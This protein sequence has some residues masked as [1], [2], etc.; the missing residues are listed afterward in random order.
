MLTESD[1]WLLPPIMPSSEKVADHYAELIEGLNLGAGIEQY[2][3]VH[4]KDPHLFDPLLKMRQSIIAEGFD[5]NEIASEIKGLSPYFLV[6]L[7]TGDG[8]VMKS[9]IDQFK[10][11]HLVIALSDWQDLATS[12]WTV[13]WQKLVDEQQSVRGGKISI[14]RYDDASDILT[15][16]ASECLTG[17]DHSLAICLQGSQAHQFKEDVRKRTLLI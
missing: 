9:L 17:V 7:G 16:L 10:P 13:D 3:D 5:P 6:V 4:M 15:F 11:H 12:F 14:A 1:F 2:I 8:R